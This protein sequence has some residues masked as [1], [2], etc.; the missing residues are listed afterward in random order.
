MAWRSDG[1]KKFEDM[2]TLFDTK[3]KRDGQQTD[4]QTYST[5]RHR[6]R[7]CSNGDAKLTK[8]RILTKSE[9]QKP[10]S[11]I[12]VI[13]MHASS[14]SSSSMSRIAGGVRCVAPTAWPR[15]MARLQSS[16]DE[17]LEY[18]RIWSIHRARGLPG[19]RPG[20]RPTDK[21]MCLRSAMCTLKTAMRP[22]TDMRRAARI[23]QGRI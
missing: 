16:T 14:S 21:S 1:D 15:R 19:R 5:R 12:I 17:L 7:L 9:K 13:I 11:M 10:L 6:Q 3:R 4:I 20:G 8:K 23:S 2:F 22:R 18:R